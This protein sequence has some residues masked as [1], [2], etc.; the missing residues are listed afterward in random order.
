M[1]SDII[2]AIIGGIIIGGAAVVMLLFLGRIAG[3]SGIFWQAV[4]NKKSF[5]L[6]GDAWRWFFIVG[7]LI[8]PLLAHYLFDINLPAASE[9]DPAT[10]IIAGIL[11]GFGTRMGSGCTSGHGICGI[12]RF[13]KRS[14]VAT[15]SFMVA[16]IATTFV[17]RHLL[18]GA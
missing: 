8:G 5:I 7:L 16:G 17:T 13:S 3:I 2:Q 11:V 15:F 12:G 14:L 18:L 4:S 10:L 6:T 1:S 9:A